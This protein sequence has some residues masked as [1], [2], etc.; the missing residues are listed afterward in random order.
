MCHRII[1]NSPTNVNTRRDASTDPRELIA[2]TE[3]HLDT[4]HDICGGSSNK[5]I[6]LRVHAV[7]TD[8]LQMYRAM[9]LWDLYT[10]RQSLLAY[11]VHKNVRGTILNVE[12]AECARK[13]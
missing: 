12:A 7:N 5:E 9:S 10:V 4:V 3:N 6:T 8:V 2:V 1:I 11:F 13:R